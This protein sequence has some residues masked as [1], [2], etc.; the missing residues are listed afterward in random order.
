[1]KKTICLILLFISSY[2]Y[3]AVPDNFYGL[4][5]GMTRE[6]VKSVMK[7]QNLSEMGDCDNFRNIS[8]YEG[9]GIELYGIFFDNIKIFFNANDCVEGFVF[10]LFIPREEGTQR[11]IFSALYEEIKPGSKSAK[12]EN[13]RYNY[14]FK[15]IENKKNTYIR[16]SIK[17][18][19][20]GNSG[21][22][23]VLTYGPT[24]RR[25][26]TN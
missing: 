15:F 26:D 24:D 4:K 11:R 8:C 14:L 5:P 21:Y 12:D 25:L 6:E 9:D 10:K 3:A 16:L 7:E 2:S 23:I 1:M 22:N 18:S 20:Q 13:I 19:L 17:E